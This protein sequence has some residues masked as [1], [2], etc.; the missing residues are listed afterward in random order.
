MPHGPYHRVETPTQ[1]S[2]DAV[3][4]VLSGEVW[5]RAAKLGGLFLCVKAYPGTLP[6]GRRG[7]QFLTPIA[8]D[9]RYSTP[10][11][12]R[13]YHPHTPGVMLRRKAGEDFA[14]IPAT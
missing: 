13:W 7:I 12:S 5:G 14:A 2:D 11:E 3:Q 1:T 4:Q 6:A 8:H 9:R 10:Y